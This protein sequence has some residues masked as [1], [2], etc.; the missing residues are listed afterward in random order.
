MKNIL[1]IVK[2]LS[3]EQL[4]RIICKFDKED[5]FGRYMFVDEGNIV[6]F[7]AKTA[8]ELESAVRGW[9]EENIDENDTEFEFEIEFDGPGLYVVSTP[10]DGAYEGARRAMSAPNAIECLSLAM[11]GDDVEKFED[12]IICMWENR[13]HDWRMCYDARY[14]YEYILRN[15]E[16]TYLGC[17]DY[18]NGSIHAVKFDGKFYRLVHDGTGNE[19]FQ[20][21]RPIELSEE[22]YEELLQ[23]A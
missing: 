20:S 10:Q 16:A 19:F 1:E 9:A 17:F 2:N 8:D 5:E 7:E 14:A 3:R 4:K 12:Y 6:I 13:M 15:G 22:E 23:E 21:R 11:V 18:P